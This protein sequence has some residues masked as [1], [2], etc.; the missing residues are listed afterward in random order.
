MTTTTW[1]GEGTLQTTVL[2]DR[3]QGRH[4]QQALGDGNEGC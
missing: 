3:S 4:A 2:N 1:G